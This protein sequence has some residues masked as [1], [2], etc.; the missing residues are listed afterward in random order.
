MAANL[1]SYR[2]G[3]NPTCGGNKQAYRAAGV[4]LPAEAVCVKQEV[5]PPVAAM[6]NQQTYRAAGGV[7]RPLQAVCFVLTNAVCYAQ[8]LCSRRII[9]PRQQTGGLWRSMA[10]STNLG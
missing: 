10:H 6:C 5:N 1:P 9:K 8:E 3:A 7:N 4:N 2:R